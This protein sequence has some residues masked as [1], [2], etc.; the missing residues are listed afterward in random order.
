MSIPTLLLATVTT[1]LLNTP[2]YGVFED[3]SYLLS[4]RD[5]LVC[6]SHA[7]VMTTSASSNNNANARSPDSGAHDS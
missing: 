3:T 5:D 4:G 6:P 1:E 7:Y 2:Y